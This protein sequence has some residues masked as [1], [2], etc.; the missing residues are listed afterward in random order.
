MKRVKIALLA[1]RDAEGRVCVIPAYLDALWGSGAVGCV[2]PYNKDKKI[3]NE[4]AEYFDGF[5]FC[6]GGDLEP[7]LYGEKNIGYSKNICSERDGFEKAV[8]EKA[9]KLDKPILGIC[10]GVQG[11]NVFLG[12]NLYQHIDNH[13]QT[14]PK[15]IREQK[16]LIK[17]GSLL[18]KI[19]GKGEI[20]TNTCH[21]QSI[22][23]LA[24]DLVYD[25]VSADGYIEAVHAQ[26]KK[27]CLG[28]QWHPECCFDDDTASKM[29]FEAFVRACGDI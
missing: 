27:F 22:K 12:G 21:H 20:L 4:T 19:V 13:S 7:A 3:L 6:G 10:R 8:F 9:Y 29:I 24:P 1:S 15:N 26:G 5:L 11:M 28:V 17:N 16:I 2:L 14:T 23:D 18:H 25:A